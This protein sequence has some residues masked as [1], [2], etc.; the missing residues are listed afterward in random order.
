MKKIITISLIIAISFFTGMHVHGKFSGHSKSDA[1]KID[2]AG[3]ASW[4]SKKSP[5]IRLR[6]ANNEIFNDS[7][8][9]F[10]K[11]K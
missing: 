2:K 8:L 11:P 7:N 5:G 1:K 4:Y 6:T 9:V 3:K 10:D